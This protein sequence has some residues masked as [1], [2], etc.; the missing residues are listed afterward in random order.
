MSLQSQGEFYLSFNKAR[1]M[2]SLS[3][4]TNAGDHRR[5]QQQPTN[6]LIKQKVLSGLPVHVT[7]S[8]NKR[9]LFGETGRY[10]ANHNT[11]RQKDSKTD[12]LAGER[13]KPRKYIF[14]RTDETRAREV[15]TELNTQ[16]TDFRSKTGSKSEQ[17][18]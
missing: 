9:L 15:K 13:G 3:E 1:P 2:V 5:K 17:N 6:P 4:Y 11:Q 16:E 14:T 7:Y 10:K 18:T 8:R 12:G